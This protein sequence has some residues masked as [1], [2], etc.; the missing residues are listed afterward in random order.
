MRMRNMREIVDV[1]SFDR[2]HVQRFPPQEQPVEARITSQ[3]A[4][5]TSS[6][7]MY[8]ER[9]RSRILRNPLTATCDGGTCRPASELENC[10]NE[11]E[12]QK[13]RI[14]TSKYSRRYIQSSE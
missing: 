14:I 3:I 13:H 11:N 2:A 6:A 4:N 12:K 5:R 7:H 1:S 9:D 10:E 8:Q